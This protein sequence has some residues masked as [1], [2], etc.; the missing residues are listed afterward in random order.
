ML[1]VRVSDDVTYMS[2]QFS[3]MSIDLPRATQVLNVLTYA[4]YDLAHLAAEELTNTISKAQARV[5]LIFVVGN[6]YLLGVSSEETA[7]MCRVERIFRTYNSVYLYIPQ[8]QL[9][10]IPLPFPDTCAGWQDERRHLVCRCPIYMCQYACFFSVS[11]CGAPSV[12]VVFAHV[13]FLG[14]LVHIISRLV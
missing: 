12:A 11:L 4:L 6:L 9:R 10:T 7:C 14:V 3:T 5:I 2:L 8:F 13:F 1:S